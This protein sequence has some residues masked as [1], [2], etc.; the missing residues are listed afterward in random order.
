M[1]I[2][3]Y[4]NLSGLTQFLENLKI[5]FATQ[6]EVSELDEVTDTYVLNVD[7]T[8]IAFDTSEIVR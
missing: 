4:L 3:K 8:Q 7:Y 1:A 5:L 6:S 2:K